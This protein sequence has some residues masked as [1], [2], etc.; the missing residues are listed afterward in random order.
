MHTIPK[1]LDYTLVELRTIAVSTERLES[2]TKTYH[3][4]IDEE[5]NACDDAHSSDSSIAETCRRKVKEQRC[6]GAQSLT[7]NRRR[8][9]FYYQS[10]VF[11]RGERYLP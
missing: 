1:A 7:G 8:S 4:G 11:F 9:T 3:Y 2:V 10:Y 6:K 5:G